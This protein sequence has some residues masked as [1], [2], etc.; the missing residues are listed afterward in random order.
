LKPPVVC[1]VTDRRTAGRPLLE[2]IREAA[3]AGVDLI[4]IRERDL[5]GGALSALVRAAV[6]AASGTDARIVV[7][8]RLDVALAAGAAGV[9]LR[10]AS[11][12]AADVR[13]LSPPGFIVGRSVHNEEEA[14]A[15]EAAGGC[16][17]LTFGTVFHSASKAAGHHAAG[18]TA[19][20]SVCARVRLPVLAIGGIGL[21][22]V[23][24]VA[25][26]GAAGIAA[27][28]LFS[29]SPD[30]EA[31]VARVRESFTAGARPI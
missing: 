8:D 15:A 22:R 12:A 19:L 20:R 2:L 10:A 21:S 7:N 26:A 14:A 23:A 31:D 17:Y 1:L 27:I 30:L 9:H 5:D 29:T 25:A 3:H 13:Q 18:L 6:D 24:D 4:Q 28:A 11:F 16:D